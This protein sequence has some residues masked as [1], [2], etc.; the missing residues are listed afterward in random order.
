MIL[1]NKS[2]IFVGYLKQLLLSFNLPT[3]RV[4]TKDDEIYKS[5]HGK[6]SPDIIRSTYDADDRKSRYVNYIK[7]NSIE[8]FFDTRDNNYNSSGVGWHKVNKNYSYNFND[9]NHVRHLII[10]DGSNYDSYTHEYLGDYLRFQRD[11]NNIDLMPL[12]NCFSNRIAPSIY[13]NVDNFSTDKDGSGTI[14]PEEIKFRFSFSSED[15]KYKIYMLPVKLFKYYTIAIDSEFPVEICCGYYDKYQN[16]GQFSLL[17]TLTYKKY[18]NLSFNNPIIYDRLSS[19]FL[20][21]ESPDKLDDTS[22]T[23]LKNYIYYNSGTNKP[24]DFARMAIAEKNLKMFIKLPANLSTSIV[25]LEGDY[26]GYNNITLNKISYKNYTAWREHSNRYVINYEEPN[27]SWRLPYY[28]SLNERSFKPITNLWLLD[29]NTGESYPF[30]P[31]LMEYLLDNVITSQEELDDNIK[32]VQK[33]MSMNHIRFDSFGLWSEKIRFYAYDYMNDFQSQ[34][35]G[36]NNHDIL[37]YIDKDVEH[38]YT[39]WKTEYIK[40]SNGNKMPVRDEKGNIIWQYYQYLL[41]I[42]FTGVEGDSDDFDNYDGKNNGYHGTTE[43]N[44]AHV[45]DRLIGTNYGQALWA[46]SDEIVLDGNGLRVPKDY[47]KKRVPLA[48]IMNVDIYDK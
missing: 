35:V 30:A 8:R 20:R 28:Q 2:H 27:L 38:Y 45:N 47:K 21:P 43:N 29:S 23:T 32:R 48:T 34:Y 5:E 25:I 14:L 9:I 18:G 3:Y 24:L 39:A 16:D 6:E 17:T 4:Y 33:V 11:Y 41:G 13:L 44:P 40:D 1:F 15:T 37:G 10:R 46:N 36:D 31:R 22:K 19:D 42:C 26:T 12:Y 7:N